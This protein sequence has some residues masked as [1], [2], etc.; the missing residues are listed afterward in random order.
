MKWLLFMVL[1]NSAGEPP[2][3]LELQ[4]ETRESC[5]SYEHILTPRVKGYWNAYS[6]GCRHVEVE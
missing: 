1:V 3:K 4:F 6:F 2:T 5:E